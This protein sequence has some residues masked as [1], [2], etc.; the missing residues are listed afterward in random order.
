LNEPELIQG[1]IDRNE[2][3]FRW[4]VDSYR[5]RIFGTVYHIL[6]NNEEAE[7]AAQDV[8][9]KVYEAIDTFK[10]SSSLSTW[11]YRIAVHK[12]L[13][14]LRRRKSRERLQKWLPAWM[15]DERRSAESD[16]QHPGLS[17]DNK[18][19]GS[20]LFKAIASLPEK[21]RVAFTLIK[22]E[23]MSYDEAAAILQQNIKAL[24]SLITRARI[25]LQKKLEQ[26]R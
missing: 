23:G 20:L 19:K 22:V 17:F 10:G 13:D 16:F 9:I 11:I 1:L 2:A 26:L 14:K 15:P 8:F 25:N 7:D 5:N 4:L 24:E 18:E 21:Q 3:A 6:Q 12:A